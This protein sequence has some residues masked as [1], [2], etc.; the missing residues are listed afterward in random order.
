MRRRAYA[1]PAPAIRRSLL[2]RRQASSRRLRERRRRVAAWRRQCCRH[3]RAT[4]LAGEQ[5]RAD[6]PQP[7]PGRR[8]RPPR[9]RCRQRAQCRHDLCCHFA[10]PRAGEGGECRAGRSR[11]RRAQFV[12]DLDRSAGAGPCRTDPRRRLVRRHHH[13]RPVFQRA[14]GRDRQC[15][16]RR[17]GAR[18]LADAGDGDRGAGAQLRSRGDRC[19]LGCRRGG[20]AISRRFAPRAVLVA[21]DPAAASTRAARERLD[22]GRLWRRDAASPARRRPRPLLKPR[23]SD[24]RAQ[25]AQRRAPS[26]TASRAA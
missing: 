16:Q 6:R 26:T 14:S 23:A 19:R 17:G 5:R 18:R 1:P 3:C 20:R 12:G 11:L 22:G 2:C 25:A 24:L 4:A 8:G 7:A 15:R 10:R 13:P 9:Q 21:A